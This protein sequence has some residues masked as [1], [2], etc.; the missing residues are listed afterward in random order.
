MPTVDPV[1]PT[2]GDPATDLLEALPRLVGVAPPPLLD[3][4]AVDPQGN[5]VRRAGAASR[6]VGFR[7]RERAVT[8]R[9]T[10]DH[11]GA[12][13]EID[14]RLTSLPYTAE[15]AET[16]ARLLSRL[17]E[18]RAIGLGQI[19]VNARHQLHLRDR[20]RLPGLPLSARALATQLCLVLLPLAPIVDAFEG[21]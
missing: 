1:P 17:A 10:E 15:S 11:D 6:T 3:G 13:L 16:R 9:L 14:C 5:L 21:L 4:L 7:W 19:A 8:A 12:F 20:V 18:A 2:R